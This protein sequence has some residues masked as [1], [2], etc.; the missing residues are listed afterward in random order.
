MADPST[1]LT[2][3][4]ND[5]GLDIELLEGTTEFDDSSLTELGAAE[6]ETTL[7]LLTTELNGASLLDGDAELDDT[8]LLGGDIEL[9]GTE[10]E[11]DTSLLEGDTELEL[12]DTA[13]E[14]SVK[15]LEPFVLESPELESLDPDSLVDPWVAVV[16][17][18]ESP[19]LESL[20]LDPEKLVSDELEP[21]PDTELLESDPVPDPVDTNVDPLVVAE[22][23]ESDPSVAA[24]ELVVDPVLVTDPELEEGPKSLVTGSVLDTELEG[25][26]I[27]VGGATELDGNSLLEGDTELELDAILLLTVETKF[28]NTALLVGEPL[29]ADSLEADDSLGALVTD[30]KSLDIE[31]LFNPELDPLVTEELDPIMLVTDPEFEPLSPELEPL[32]AVPEIDAL[33]A[34]S[35][36]LDVEL[37]PPELSPLV[38]D[39]ELLVTDPTDTELLESPLVIISELVPVSDPD[40]V[41][42]PDEIVAKPGEAVSEVTGPLDAEP[43]KMESAE[44]ESLVADAD[45]LASVPVKVD[46]EPS[47]ALVTDPDSLVAEPLVEELEIKLKLLESPELPE[48]F[49]LVTD[50]V[51]PLDT[52]LLESIQLDSLGLLALVTDP[53]VESEDALL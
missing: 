25:V 35:D 5:A 15:E 44:L 29:G 42:D 2:A 45:E 18:L 11:L 1:L 50:P 24:V 53:V 28:D 4:V 43:V 32:E 40:V 51:V 19:E 47:F 37:F 48:F 33:V 3:E 7:L 49:S 31:L 14:S 30:P 8:S 34:K 46:A 38:E 22:P 20:A 52:G 16:E 23:L 27:P 36:P 10:L 13:L 12:D 21:D 39:V 26:S 17:L 9:G 41:T 6:L